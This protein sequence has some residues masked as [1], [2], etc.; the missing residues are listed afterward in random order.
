[1]PYLTQ[2]EYI[3]RYGNAETIR[4][5]DET[6]SGEVDSAKL[7]TAIADA[8]DIIDAYLGSRY[9]LP[10]TSVPTLVKHA[11]AAL[12]R[13]I[14]HTSRPLDTVTAEAERVR[15]QLELIAKGT[16][17]LPLPLNATAPI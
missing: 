7:A 6:R 5:T 4:I 13:E 10:L 9:L 1:M 11:N 8:S 12:A 16:L 14:L 17:T 15:R 2:T 3:S